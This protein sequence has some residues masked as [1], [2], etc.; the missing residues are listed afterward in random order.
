MT[1]P[2]FLRTA[3]TYSSYR[4]VCRKYSRKSVLQ[5]SYSASFLLISIFCLYITNTQNKTKCMPY[6]NCALT[7]LKCIISIIIIVLQHHLLLNCV[8]H[9]LPNF[10]FVLLTHSLTLLEVELCPFDRFT[11][12]SPILPIWRH[13]YNLFPFNTPK[14]TTY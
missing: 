4:F 6:H 9:F 3:W 8:Q 2:S 12:C 7:F 11:F 5:F 14:Y 13:L 1:F 10:T